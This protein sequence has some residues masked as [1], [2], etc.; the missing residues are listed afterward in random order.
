MSDRR[1]SH[2]WI[3]IL[4]ATIAAA[5]LAAADE[6]VDAL[7]V[8]AT[9]ADMSAELAADTTEA[10]HFSVAPD[11]GLN[12]LPKEKVLGMLAYDGPMQPGSCIYDNECLRRTHKELGTRWFIVVRLSASGSGYG[13]TVVRIAE[14]AEL[15]VAVNGE[16]G[17]SAAELINKCR[18]LVV[19]AMKTPLATLVFSVN[20]QDATVEVGGKVVGQGSVTVEVRPGTYRVRITKEGFVPFDAKIACG[21]DRQCIVPVNILPLQR[22]PDPEPDPEPDPG[23]PVPDNTPQILQITGWSA[24][25]VGAAMTVVGVIFGVNAANNQSDLDAA[26]ADPQ[27]SITR[28][29]ARAMA[30]DGEQGATLFNAVGIPGMI[31]LV[32]GVTTAVIGH[33]IEPETKQELEVTPALGLDGSVFLNAR[34]RF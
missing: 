25:G 29:D 21:A 10:L 33:I 11:T 4:V 20:E 19:S 13:I 26:C 9:G 1:L 12:F 34:L 8:V 28:Q 17:H 14:S 15:D 22:V 24:A 7:V 5:P 23:T 6:P 3:P 31:L 27:C 32:G 2:S 18:G 30:N 16:S